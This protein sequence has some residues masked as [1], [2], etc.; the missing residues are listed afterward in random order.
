ML[1][2]ERVNLRE[3][4]RSIG[5]EK[6]RKARKSGKNHMYIVGAAESTSAYQDLYLKY[7]QFGDVQRCV[8]V[9]DSV[10]GY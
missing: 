2:L 5:I 9:G 8:R 7:L 3:W 10:F 6:Y 4:N 1:S